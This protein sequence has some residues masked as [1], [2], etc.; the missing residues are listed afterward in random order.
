MTITGLAWAPMAIFMFIFS[1]AVAGSV[2]LY[3]DKQMKKNHLK[4]RIQEMTEHN[5]T[6]GGDILLVSGG[7]YTND[8]SYKI[9]QFEIWITKFV[10][11][12]AQNANAYYRLRFE[13]AGWA[14]RKALFI[15]IISTVGIVLLGNIGFV[16]LLLEVN[17]VSKRSFIELI[18]YFVIINFFSFRL[19]EYALDFIIRR[20]YARIQKIF[21]FCV[22]LLSICTKAG[23]SVDKSFEKIGGE[24]GFYNTD[25][26]WE[27]IRVSLELE[28]N[29]N[30][31]DVLHSFAQR[32]NIPMN[33]ILVGGLIHAEEQGVSIS[34]TLNMLSQEFSKAKALEIEAKAARLPVLLTIPL[35]L[36]FLPVL[37]IILFAPIVAHF[38]LD[39]ILGGQ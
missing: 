24:I 2:T 21:I 29:P 19:F 6:G 20:R 18:L 13:Q 35:A 17:F 3:Y 37:F 22:D 38:S 12:Y 34:Q 15:T 39:S 10:S 36:F 26:C 30:R 5:R 27:F 25:V 1:L 31:Q 32:L 9:R 14:S 4:R 28:M 7:E 16:L 33:H 8:L 11:D 23:L